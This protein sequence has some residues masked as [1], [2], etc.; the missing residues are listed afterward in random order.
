MK[1][2]FRFKQ[3]SVDQTNCAM[4]INTDG[5]LLGALAKAIDLGNILDI[6]TGTGVIALM[7]AQRFASAIIDAVEIDE[8]AAQTAGRN[9]EG[10]P[11]A[12][13]LNIFPLPVQSFF[14][15]YPDRKYDLIV[16][17]PPFHLNSLES[18][19]AG[20]S[21][22]KH[23][24]EGFFEGLIKG[25][26]KHLAENGKCWLIL[27]LQA[28]ELVNDI[29]RRNGLYLQRKVAIHS[30]EGSE[31]HRQIVVFGKE[32]MDVVEE[33]FVIYNEPKVYSEIYINTLKDFFTI[34]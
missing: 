24:D 33:R 26:A 5:V 28:S 19:K 22:A 14:S 3:F 7:L 4:K 21:L 34:F 25:I 2:V 16:S 18:P 29:A 23:T 8:A 13:R 30:F 27:P 10:S 20:K 9:F 15:E 11:F 32:G 31:P 17:N 1:G 6:G 12:D